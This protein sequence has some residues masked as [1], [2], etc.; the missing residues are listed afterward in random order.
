[1]FAEAKFRRKRRRQD[2]AKGDIKRSEYESARLARPKICRIKK[3]P[4]LGEVFC[5]LHLDFGVYASRQR[6]IL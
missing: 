6:E 4:F 2:P 1:M 3:P 5:V